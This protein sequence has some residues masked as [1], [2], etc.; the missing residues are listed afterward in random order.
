MAEKYEFIKEVKSE[1]NFEKVKFK[2]KCFG[3][4]F[5]LGAEVAEAYDGF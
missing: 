1:R 4:L 5:S 2:L 3:L